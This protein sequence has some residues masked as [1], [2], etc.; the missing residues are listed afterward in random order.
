[1]LRHVPHMTHGMY[2]WH[3]IYSFIL[4]HM[5]D[6]GWLTVNFSYRVVLVLLL[7]NNG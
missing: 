5:Y 2:G 1:M 7:Y 3:G 6:L 4:G